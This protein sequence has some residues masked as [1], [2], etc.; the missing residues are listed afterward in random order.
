MTPLYPYSRISNAWK[1]MKW[2]KAQG[3]CFHFC[4]SPN[5]LINA[6]PRPRGRFAQLGHRG[7]RCIYALFGAFNLTLKRKNKISRYTHLMHFHALVFAVGGKRKASP[8]MLLCV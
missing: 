2:L 3:L 6:S 7:G 8:E 4:F 1:C 5:A